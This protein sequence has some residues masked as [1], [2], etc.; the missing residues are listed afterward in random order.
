MILERK[1]KNM[2]KLSYIFILLML[3]TVVLISC[4]NSVS[5]DMSAETEEE[6][7]IVKT[8]GYV[9][10]TM[11]SPIADVNSLDVI[12]ELSTQ[13]VLCSIESV[14]KIS[15]TE[16][17]FLNF[18]YNVKILDIYMDTN[19][20]L[21]IGDVIPVSTSEGII[22]ANEAAEM[23]KYSSRAQ[24]YGIVQGDYADNEYFVSSVWN[25]IPIEVGKQYIMYL[26]D[27]YLE[28]D[29]VYAEGGRQFLYEY[30]EQNVYSTRDRIPESTDQVIE[31]IK[32][33]IANRTGRAD[34]IGYYPYLDELAEK[35]RN[36]KSEFSDIAE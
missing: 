11:G 12:T 13:T 33:H 4:E 31:K 8:L 18:N 29:G 28:T 1:L 21:E 16:M 10:L 36:E 3:L 9:D 35:Q 34:E 14:E 23:F 6:R 24:K 2:S 32:S 5:S 20:R 27:E 22:K 30:T 7:V 19:D 26:T 15:T 25:A 17:N